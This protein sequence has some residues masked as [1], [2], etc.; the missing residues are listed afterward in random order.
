MRYEYTLYVHTRSTYMLKEYV[1][2]SVNQYM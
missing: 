2:I 1:Y